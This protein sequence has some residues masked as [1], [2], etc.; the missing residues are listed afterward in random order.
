VT[1]DLLV[2]GPLLRHVDTATA[3][4]W[5]ETRDAATVTVTVAGRSWS[6]RTFAAHGHHYA[7]VDVD[8]L[9]AGAR[10]PY[11]VAV[12]GTTVWP[13]VDSAY[14]PSVL[15]TLEEGRPL[16][17]AYGSCRTSVA[18][19]E[20][21]HRTHGVDAMRAYALALAEGDRH[22]GDQ[23]RPDL[24]LFLGDQ[25]YAD[26][27][28]D[29]MESF[30]RAR[31]DIEEPPWDELKDFEE[32]AHLYRL[33][34]TDPANR[35]LL[36]TVPTLMIFDDHDVR[37]DW[38]TSLG[39]KQR[40]E[41]TS[42]WHERIVSGLGS[43]WVYQHLGNLTP[44]ERARDELWRLV[45][46]GPGPGAEEVDLTEPLDAFADRVDQHP[47]SYR[48]SLTRD[49][50]D[51]RLVVVDSRAARVLDPDHRSMLDP[52]EL[53]WLDE[54][55]QG[56]FRH[57]LVGT[58]LP[59]LLSPG[60]HHLEAWDEAL[61]EGA[62]GERGARFG[63][64]LRQIVDLEHWAAFQH[65][66]AEV[67]E[68][69]LS[70]AYGERGRAP[71]TV[72]FLSGDVHHSYLSEVRKVFETATDMKRGSRVEGRRGER[73]RILQA[74]CSPMRNPLPRVMRFATAVLSYGLAGPMGAVAA[75]SA[76]VPDPPCTWGLV[77]GPWFDND[78]ALLQDLGEEGLE[79]SWWTGVVEDGRH[80]RPRLE[81][82]ATVVVA[83]GRPGHRQRLGGPVTG[84]VLTRVSRF[85]ARLRRLRAARSR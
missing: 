59:F 38:N 49:L 78:I 47:T 58:S 15:A 72:T 17:L 14:P 11:Q 83:P 9:P 85:V 68:M 34:W 80:D 19:D 61:V 18:H 81:E 42:W 28:T 46:A 74:V 27:T 71:D 70:V 82:V 22:R 35:W 5:V 73:S 30:I 41:A 75:R 62:W 67:A 24:L 77:R 7:L 12:D 44:A 50:G 51:V 13:P 65:G 6:A 52:G 4:V 48:W 57:L 53:A 37:D 69:A 3:T 45:A 16:R 40:M 76:H 1:Q 20:H 84:K 32:Y 33:A 55:M 36:S 31:R 25:V 23:P 29:E 64:W 26:E 79:L 2:L 60:L 43:Y 63:E 8:G 66:F 54:Q 56:G 10:Q 21:G 39:W